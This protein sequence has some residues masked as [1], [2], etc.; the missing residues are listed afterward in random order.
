M[1]R[2][3]GPRRRCS[4][5]GSLPAPG[6]G[7]SSSAVTDPAGSAGA[8]AP[9]NGRTPAAT[10][11]LKQVG[12]PGEKAVQFKDSNEE[13]DMIILVQATVR[14]MGDPVA[15]II[16]ESR[17]LA[18]DGCELVEVEYEPLPVVAEAFASKRSLLSTRLE[19]R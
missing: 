6:V 14:F 15:T 18:E 13:L 5:S 8:W 11:W 10:V 1:R 2:S 4:P 7:V 3:V 17:Y 19:S 9:A 16:A 12:V